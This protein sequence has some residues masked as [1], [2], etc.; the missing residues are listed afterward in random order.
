M[1]RR[2]GVVRDAPDHR[3]RG[4]FRLTAPRILPK[5]VSLEGYLGPVKEQGHEGSC[6]AFAGAGHREYLYRRYQEN[7]KQPGLRVEDAVFSPQYLFYRVHE[8]E[9]TLGEDTGGQIRSVVK[10]LHTMGI[11]LEKSDAY[12]SAKAWATPT[13]AQDAEAQLFEAGAYHRLATVDDMKSCLASGYTFIAGFAV[14]E[15]F[16]KND[17]LASAVMPI[18]KAK[19][20]L[21]GGHAVLFFGYDDE[22]LA[23]KVRN[24]WGQ[25]W[26]MGG[27]FWFP[28]QAAADPNIFWDGWIQHLGKAW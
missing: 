11:C 22:R 1:N 13:A 21:L 8:L 7:E 16:E 18:P 28:Y 10:T 26:G 2:Y 27:N 20:A 6:F 24:S 15:S 17:W 19:D 3:D 4:V 5:A 25:A 9:G 23:F 14:H 12:N